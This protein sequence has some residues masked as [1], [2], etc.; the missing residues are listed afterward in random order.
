[1]S[2]RDFTID[3]ENAAT[4]I[5]E[6]GLPSFLVAVKNRLQGKAKDAIA[7]KQI[8]TV[9]DLITALKKFFAPGGTY[10]DY[11]ARLQSVRRQ[12]DETLPE[13]HL[14]VLRLQ[15][16][17]QAALVSEYGREGNENSPTLRDMAIHHFKVGL[18]PAMAGIMALQKPATLSDAFEL[19]CEI[20][21]SQGRYPDRQ[22]SQYPR[23]DGPFNPRYDRQPYDRQPYDRQ[24][25]PRR[26]DPTYEGRRDSY[27][28]SREQSPE[29]PRRWSRE[30]E[31]TPRSRYDSYHSPKGSRTQGHYERQRDSYVVTQSVSPDPP[32]GILRREGS[33]R[34]FNQNQGSYERSYGDDYRR[35]PSPRRSEDYNSQTQRRYASEAPR[36]R[37]RYRDSSPRDRNY[38]S[39]R[40]ITP[41][42][43]RRNSPS[44]RSYK[45]DASPA[46]HSGEQQHH[47]QNRQRSLSPANPLNSQGTRRNSA[48]A[49]QPSQAERSIRFSESTKE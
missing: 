34:Y 2:L 20:E 32:R 7:G 33:P 23:S 44:E 17:A 21:R 40:D 14:R 26:Y 13:F 48:A 46:R 25:S 49:S 47:Y 29:P 28:A 41:P 42:A 24:Q 38:D 3:V 6:A 18:G 35:E 31:T 27:L 9:S 45:N 8:T 37:D 36:W 19:A 43:Y 4:L 11:T 10:A 39:R 16:S 5:T 15:T 22:R 12:V 30:S 1:M